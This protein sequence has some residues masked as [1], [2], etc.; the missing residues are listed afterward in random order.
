VLTRSRV[1]RFQAVRIPIAQVC[2]TRQRTASVQRASRLMQIKAVTGRVTPKAIRHQRQ[3]Y[4]D[5]SSRV[6]SEG[7]TANAD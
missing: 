5:R 6:I 7:V 3:R 1:E 4:L 2:P